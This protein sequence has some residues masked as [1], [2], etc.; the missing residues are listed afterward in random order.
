MEGKT[1]LQYVT[2]IKREEA[3]DLTIWTV[4]LYNFHR[5]PT[6][7]ARM[8]YGKQLALCRNP[9]ASNVDMFC[10]LTLPI[11]I[12]QPKWMG[13]ADGV[14]A[15][16]HGG[17]RLLKLN[18]VAVPAAEVTLSVFFPPTLSPPL[19]HQPWQCILP[20]ARL[21]RIVQNWC[22]RILAPEPKWQRT[23]SGSLV[24]HSSPM[25]CWPLRLPLYP[26]SPN[27]TLITPKSKFPM[28]PSVGC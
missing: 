20:V 11:P 24:L 10:F 16:V 7:D 18:N 2:H 27:C 23:N 19:F 13:H 8:G 22:C 3:T 14:K 1:E 17:Q 6:G 26:S 5:F 15:L 25:P 28:T 4:L 12:P 21:S 9:I